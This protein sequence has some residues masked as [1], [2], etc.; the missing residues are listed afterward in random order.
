MNGRR[1]GV[2]S[3][4]PAGMPAVVPP[5]LPAQGDLA[6]GDRGEWAVEFAWAGFRCVAYV[7]PG[8]VRL[9][10]STARTVTGSFPELAVLGERVRG[11]GMVLDGVVVALD[12]AGR[13]SRRPLMRRT[14]TV[15]PSE[16]LR[17]RVPIGF[18][19]TDLLWLDGRPLLRRPYAE[20]RELLEGLG[21]AGA[22]IL[23]PPSHPASDAAFVMETAERYGLDG[24]H[25]K[26]ADA[27]YKAGRRTRDWLR[28]PLRRSRP[29]VVGGW[30]PA[31]PRKPGRPG[32]L[33]LG[34]PEVD[35]PLRYVGRVGIG[36]GAARREI[37]ELLRTHHA[38]L[39]PFDEEGP[40]AVPDQ[41][42]DDARWLRPE[43]VGSAEYQ[44]WTRGGHLRLP[45]WAGVEAA[46]EIDPEAWGG[47]PWETEQTEQAEQAERAEQARQSGPT[48]Q[49]G[50]A[51]QAEPS[52]RERP[53]GRTGQGGRAGQ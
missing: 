15:A 35:G 23:V 11:S 17:E 40:G 34:I 44:G 27:S 42:A 48:G 26:R 4:M 20:R 3:G 9:L 45:V 1:G 50:Q 47:T 41:V 36:S 53:S 2:G 21:I 29:V 51:Q 10:S 16:R 37:A 46:E 5:M 39:S 52:E 30:M 19:A 25:L 28:V 22:P 6:D 13:P 7:L 32:A 31:D 38:Q 33:L 43:I 49:P 14:S 24:L 12:D 8:R 18:V